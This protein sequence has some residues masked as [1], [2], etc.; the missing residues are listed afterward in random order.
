[1]L[2]Y[3]KEDSEILYYCWKIPELQ[4]KEFIFLLILEHPDSCVII[5]SFD[6]YATLDLAICLRLALR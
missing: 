6:S 2:S 1:M 3:C 4:A 5:D